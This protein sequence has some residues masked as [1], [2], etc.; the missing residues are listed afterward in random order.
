[1]KELHKYSRPPLP[2]NAVS[3]R[4]SEHSGR[5]R[6]LYDIIVLDD[7]NTRSRAREEHKD[8]ERHDRSSSS[9]GDIADRERYDSSSSI[10]ER[11][12]ALNQQLSH[13]SHNSQH[14]YEYASLPFT[15]RGVTVCALL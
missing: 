8:E 1:M 5:F 11:M 9:G 15:V 4:Y 7:E 3:H 13:L 14:V 10:S 6:S 2:P 12:V